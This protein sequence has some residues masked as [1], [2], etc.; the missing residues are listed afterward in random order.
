MVQRITSKNYDSTIKDIIQN[1][2]PSCKN[3][4]FRVGYFYF[5][6]FSLIAEV[7]KNKNVKILIGMETDNEVSS[8]VNKSNQEIQNNYFNSFLEKADKDRVLDSADEQDAYFIFEEKLR[9]GTLE[10]KQQISGSD[11]S[12]EYLF[13][14]DNKISLSTGIK[15]RTLTGSLNLSKSGLWRQGETASD[16]NDNNYFEESKN[17]FMEIWDSSSSSIPLVNKNNFQQFK[18]KTKKLSFKQTPSPYLMFVRV[19]NEY[20]KDR[21]DGNLRFPKQI[22]NSKFNDYKYQKDAVT[23]GFD[24]INEHNGVLIA[25]VVGLGKS[26]IASTIANNLNIPTF[27]ITP[28]HLKKAWDDYLFEFKVNKKIFTTGELHK[29]LD[30]SDKHKGQKLIIIDEAHKFRNDETA[31]YLKLYQI[32]HG[33]GSGKP[34]KVLLLSATPFNNHPKDTFSLIKLFQIPTRS[35]LQTIS[36]LSEYFEQ[37]TSKY[38]KLKREQIKSKRKQKEIDDDFQLIGEQIR[39]IITPVMIRRSRIDLKKIKVYWD[40]LEKLGM[41][42]PKVKDPILEEYNLKDIEKIYIDT[43]KILNPT[44]KENK[45]KCSRYKPLTYV[46]PEAMEKILTRGGYD[47][48]DGKTSLPV[49]QQNIADFMKRLLV[50]RFE[51]CSHSFFKTLNKI[52]QSSE[53]IINYYEKLNVVPI[54]KKGEIP[55]YEEIFDLDSFDDID[56]KFSDTENI[57]FDDFK[58]LPKIQSLENKG[59]WF[60]KK[61]EL[62]EKYIYDVKRDLTVLNEIKSNWQFTQEKNFEDPKIKSFLK[63]INDQIK[64]EPKRKIIIFSEFS[65]TVEY[66]F[67][68]M[69]DAKFKVFS[70]TS[71]S[72]SN[73]NIKETISKNFDA[74]VKDQENKYDILVATDAISEGFNLHRAGTIF[75]FDIPYNPTR[76]VQRFGRINRINKKVFDEL[77]IYNYFPSDPGE[78][79]INMGR[80][81]ALKKMMFNSI[82]GDD[83]RVLTKNE[84]LKSFFVEE[85]KKNYEETESPETYYENIIYNLRDYEKEV[86]LEAESI[87]KR[88]KCKRKSDRIKKG[89]ILF[90]KKG[91]I[92]RFENNQLLNL[93]DIDYLKIF[94]ADK[95]EKFQPFERKYEKI[96]EEIKDKIFNE[97]SLLSSPNKKKKDLILKLQKLKEVSKFTSYIDLLIKVIS[98]LDALTPLQTKILR[99]ISYK[100]FD[101][102]INEIESKIPKKLLTNLIDTYNDITNRKEALIIT[103]QIND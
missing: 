77:Y 23:K 5:S 55:D 91:E 84:D 15:G 43:L 69:K 31:D 102:N 57:N 79:E 10:I 68:K 53:I 6:G 67:S 20:F 36:N 56:K 14:Y 66:V 103:Q 87:S 12:K 49:Q 73:Q 64:K 8:L 98:D 26:I 38:N 13:E 44:S 39:K 21:D 33:S 28:P 89:V 35:T 17:D 95:K 94:E 78:K 18:E 61:E 88:V 22:T 7:I 100:N 1:C 62:K 40:D 42:I 63:I 60:I 83:T 34:N 45:Y 82:F 2:I 48:V 92:P 24:I 86:I 65:D 9:N 75:N 52:I 97:K 76:V 93:T 37:L 27:V 47:A 59:M 101:K 70:Y 32:C 54:Y 90:S 4:Y 29:A 96:Y 19:L 51:S 41:G 58:S 85:F 30:E 3:I 74:S 71:K 16:I 50:R 11:H 72:S 80:I 99:D 25:D 46:K 81:T